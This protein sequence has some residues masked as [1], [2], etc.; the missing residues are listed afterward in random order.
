MEGS[1]MAGGADSKELKLSLKI[2]GDATKGSSALQAIA[3]DAQ[4]ASDAVLGLGKHI[5]D[6]QKHSGTPS[7]LAAPAWMGGSS[8]PSA[9]TGQ[10][11]SMSMPGGGYDQLISSI[12]SLTGAIRELKKT[13]DTL[14]ADYKLELAGG[15][16][17]GSEKVK[18]AGE[19]K[20]HGG[21]GGKKGGK[22]PGRFGQFA[23]GLGQ[24][25][26]VFT[27]GT[28][29]MGLTKAVGG[30]AAAAGTVELLA[31]LTKSI[32]GLDNPLTTTRE[33][34]LGL[35]ESIPV[36]GTALSNL[37]S[38]VMSAV[39]R[40]RDPETAKKVDRMKLEQPVILGQMQARSDY[41]TRRWKLE[42]EVQDAEF[43]AQSVKA[44]PSFDAAMHGYSAAS[45]PAE[46]GSGGGW[47]NMLAG[48]I[49]TLT[50]LARPAPST[51]SF[52]DMFHEQSKLLESRFPRGTGFS[53]GP[54]PSGPNER[55][56]SI[57]GMPEIHLP[58]M[59]G[60]GLG[61][62]EGGLST[63]WQQYPQLKAAF[64]S[65]QTALRGGDFAKRQ[66]DRSG[67]E[68]EEQ[69]AKVA[70]ARKTWQ[71]SVAESERRLQDARSVGGAGGSGGVISLPGSSLLPSGKGNTW[72]DRVV[73]G[74]MEMGTSQAAG[75]NYAINGG[76]G[77]GPGGK[78][79]PM[80][81]QEVAMNE[82]KA[83]LDLKQQ[84]ADLEAKESKLKENSLDYT[85]QQYEIE[86]SRTGILQSQ[87]SIY[88]QQIA[89]AKAGI[90][91]FGMLDKVGQATILDAAKRFKA[92]GRMGVT[93]EELGMLRS[94]AITGEWVGQAVGRNA[95]NDPMTKE[96]MNLTGQKDLGQL[97]EQKEKLEK[98]ISVKVQMDEV[99]FADAIA[100]Q[101]K[102]SNINGLLKEVVDNLKLIANRKPE[103]EAGVG[104]A[105]VAAGTP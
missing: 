51:A 3:K 13:T 41:E 104:R 27:A 84:L 105:G 11:V 80:H 74:A 18:S 92:Q 10:S 100:A 90:E 38:N 98:E 65:H 82:Q 40:L 48:G 99:K 24:G 49:G 15:K 42:G 46:S 60:V 45:S 93:E 7:H 58:G 75:I 29:A 35:V 68:V 5:A 37:T 61:P 4:K 81:L 76:S 25:E 83:A 16:S 8:S 56:L 19:G 14:D 85:K 62:H 101:M 103:F 71:A 21:G 12:N 91:S 102:E 55:T 26:D 97:Q 39:D 20:E 22:A 32:Q 1:N 30:V 88:D 33:K 6:V 43:K 57:P 89:K 2:E 9:G 50:G 96:L 77:V 70:N 94:N 34:M 52:D 73:A 53:G 47:L 31:N 67:A 17:E 63:L 54:V 59:A 64:E 72:I 86:R 66:M 36:L 87:V 23:E 78:G 44:V 95:A 79:S 28:N 69:K